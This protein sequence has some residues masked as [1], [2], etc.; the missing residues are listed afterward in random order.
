[1]PNVR[2]GLLLVIAGV[3]FWSTA[4]LFARSV[5]LDPATVLCWR[6]AFG[7]LGAFTLMLLWP[8]SGGIG[9]LRRLGRP[10]LLYAATGA[11]STL[12]YVT[13]VLSTTVAHVSILQAC[14][15]FAAAFLGWLLL[16]ERPGRA[17]LLAS[18]AA[19]CG[20][21]LMVGTRGEGSL[22]GDLLAVGMALTFGCLILISRRFPGIPAFAAIGLSTGLYSLM[23]LPFADLT[24]PAR[25]ILVLAGFGLMQ[26]PGFLLFTVGARHLPPT[27]T[28]LLAALDAPL[29][30]LWVWLVFGETPSPATIAGGLV[31]LLAVLWFIRQQSRDA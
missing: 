2:L 27:A 14:A 15:P 13:A 18:A 16:R 26:V 21:V 1:M 24:L 8:G 7:A 12:F 25:D 29:S 4:G 5:T 31:V 20:I 28:A 19:L 17:A 11:V 6:G 23:A 3:L 22:R 10:G 30:P 9:S